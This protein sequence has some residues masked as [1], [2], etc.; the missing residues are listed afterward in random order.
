MAA[1]EIRPQ[2]RQESFLATGAD[3]AV[4]GGAA[5]GG[6]TW[7]LLLEPLR[8]IQNK[9]FGAVV[10]R[11]TIP[12]ITNEGALWDEAAKIYPLL[13]AKANENDKQYTFP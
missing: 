4:Y 11:R 10:F 8:H 12:E 9:D 1:T 2:P 3:I 5:G 7:A 6:K 13:S